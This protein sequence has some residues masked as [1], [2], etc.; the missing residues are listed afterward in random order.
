LKSPGHGIFWALILRSI[1]RYDILHAQKIGD[2][3]HFA[4][5]STGMPFLAEE[6]QFIEWRQLF[7]PLGDKKIR[8][9]IQ[10]FALQASYETPKPAEKRRGNL[11]RCA[12]EFAIPKLKAFSFQ[13]FELRLQVHPENMQSTKEP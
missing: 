13:K 11:W 12:N 2:L 10:K 6:H 7:P 5:Q 4:I 3:K 1:V 8:S 9:I